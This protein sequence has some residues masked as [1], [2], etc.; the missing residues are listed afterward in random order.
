MRV[1]VALGGNALLR[2]GEPA[3][4]EIQQRNVEAATAAIARLAAEHQLVVTHGNG[5]QVGLLALQAAAYRGVAP[6]PLDV[7][8]AESEGM[9]GYLLEQGLRNALPGRDVATLVTQIV[10]DPRDPAFGRPSKPIGP[11]YDEGEAQLVAA[12]SGWSIAPDGA[13]WR[14]VVPSPEP[15]A[16]VELSTIRLLLEAGVIVVCAGGGGIPVTADPSGALHG[17]EAV[18]DKD[19]ASALLA[20]EIGADRLLLLSDVPAVEIDWGLDTARP[21][22]ETT[23]DELRSHAFAAGSMAPKVEAVCRFV[24]ATGREA[25]IGLLTEAGEILT[26]AAGT[27]VRPRATRHRQGRAHRGRREETRATTATKGG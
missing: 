7:L 25:A 6:Y 17:I 16:I 24:E 11:V 21:L 14:R 12:A 8:G 23:P 22:E 15:V 18:I 19:L 13:G 2:R 26:G 9:I 4:A 3:D 20:R 1:V 27:R 10:V 5:P